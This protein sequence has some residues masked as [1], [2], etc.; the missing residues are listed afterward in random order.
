MSSVGSET[1]RQGSQTL[2]DEGYFG[3]DVD[4]MSLDDSELSQ[5]EN[6][7]MSFHG[8]AYFDV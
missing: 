5:E 3:T 6:D 2:E 1:L 4:E 8:S 7:Y